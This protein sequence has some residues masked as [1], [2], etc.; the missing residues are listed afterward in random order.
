MKAIALLAL[1]I[2][3]C[4]S[5]ESRSSDAKAEF[6]LVKSAKDRLYAERDDCHQLMGMFSEDV[7]F[8]EKGNRMTYDFLVEYCQNFRKK[9]GSLR[10]PHPSASC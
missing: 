10:S 9:S 4:A 3:A 6:L 8:W 1:A 2:A 7:V 5:S